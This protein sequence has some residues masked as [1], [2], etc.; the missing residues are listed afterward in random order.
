MEWA[1]YAALEE[2]GTTSSSYHGELAGMIAAIA[3]VEAVAIKYGIEGT[4]KLIYN[5]E[6]AGAHLTKQSNKSI[7]LGNKKDYD[8]IATLQKVILESKIKIVP[9]WVTSHQT[10]QPFTKEAHLNNCADEMA[11]KGHN[12]NAPRCN[13]A[14]WPEQT[15]RIAINGAQCPGNWR[16]EIIENIQGPEYEKYLKEKF[17]WDDYTLGLVDWELHSSLEI[18]KSPAER[19]AF[20]KLTHRWTDTGHLARSSGETTPCNECGELETWSH[21]L[22]CKKRTEQRE[23]HWKT[24]KRE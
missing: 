11:A 16:E 18:R 20:C 22:R 10:T 7:S 23:A 9:I 6:S 12:P 15:V 17:H 3:A 19:A 5:S 8:L 21:V 4:C 24:C 13:P 1:G 2:I 14:E